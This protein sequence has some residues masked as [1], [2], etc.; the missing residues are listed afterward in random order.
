MA[1]IECNSC[2]KS[3]L[4]YTT[5]PP[6]QIAIQDDYK[7][8]CGTKAALS[9]D[10]PLSFE[11]HGNGDDFLDIG[12]CEL[13][14]RVRLLKNDNNL[15]EHEIP[16]TA[17]DATTAVKPGPDAT[18]APVNNFF[19]SMF[20]QVDV[21]LND[22]LISQSTNTYPYR[23]YISSLLSYSKDVKDTWLNMEMW[24]KDEPKKFDSDDNEGHQTRLKYAM[25]GREFELKS[26]LHMDL[27]FQSR[28]IPNGVDARITLTRSKPQFALMY[29]GEEPANYTIDITYAVLEVRKVK[30]VPKFQL[31][32]EETFAK[33][34]AKIP[35]NHVTTKN[36]SIPQGISTF[37]LDSLF[38]GQ[39]PNSI[40]LGLLDN[41]SFHGS[42]SKNPFNFQHFDLSFLCLNVEGKQIPGRPLQPDYENGYYL[43]C[44]Q[45]LFTGTRIYGDDHSH[46]ITLKDYAN[47]YCLYA[48]NL[49]PD[50]S[51]G[52]THVN[53]RKHGSVRA[54]IHFAKPLPNTVTLIAMGQFDNIIT[55]DKHRNV[56]FDYST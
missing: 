10:A 28:L 33:S 55:I 37:N 19:H 1:E 52:T 7:I 34:G 29:F 15:V 49:T 2:T 54:S 36:F 47:G 45:T 18:L 26:R 21:V 51:E 53:E 4:V 31:H 38:T 8:Y 14:L 25:N 9:N 17:T 50:Q 43:N 56:L 5:I 40:V 12:D 42:Y 6:K 23:A 27:T 22:N 46:G 35:V 11:I 30:L 39:L 16:N 41:D 48:F 13:L 24:A 20:S 3:E 32:L 44:Y